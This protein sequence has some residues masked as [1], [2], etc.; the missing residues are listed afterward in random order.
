MIVAF[1]PLEFRVM[2]PLL[3]KPLLKVWVEAVEETLS[4][5]RLAPVSLTKAALKVSLK[6]VRSRDDRLVKAPVP[7]TVTVPPNN[8]S[9]VAVVWS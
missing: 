4:I 2:V 1:A 8:R 3:V 9:V 5:C 6:P 7:I